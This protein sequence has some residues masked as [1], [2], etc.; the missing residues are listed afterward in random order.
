MKLSTTTTTYTMTTTMAILKSHVLQL[1]NCVKR[2]YTSVCDTICVES[3]QGR[4][5]FLPRIM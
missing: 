5:P 2:F 3:G 1:S 4:L